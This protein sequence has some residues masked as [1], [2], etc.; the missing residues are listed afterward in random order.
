MNISDIWTL[1][2]T[3]VLANKGTEAQEAMPHPEAIATA[4]EILALE[5]TLGINVASQR[6]LADLTPRDGTMG[7]EAA[8][9]STGKWRWTT[10]HRAPAW[11]NSIRPRSPC[12]DKRAGQNKAVC[13]IPISKDI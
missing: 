11:R 5:H 10:D 6:V 12:H 7:N 4:L 8:C 9:Y 3:T 13:T 1:F 2:A